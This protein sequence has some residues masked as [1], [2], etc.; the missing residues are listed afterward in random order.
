MLTEAE[1]RVVRL[2]LSKDDDFA[3]MK[4]QIYIECYALGC[5]LEWKVFQPST[6]CRFGWHRQLK[7]DLHIILRLL[8][9]VDQ[10]ENSL[11]RTVM[12]E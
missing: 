2:L 4:I 6:V 3:S 1:Q 5:S 10:E 8:E 12:D 11:L 9:T 7:L